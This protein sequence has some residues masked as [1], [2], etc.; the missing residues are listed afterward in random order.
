M[1]GVLDLSTTWDR[2]H[3]LAI[4]T[5][6]VLGQ[7]V[8]AAMPGQSPAAVDPVLHLKVLGGWGASVAGNPLVLPHRQ[9]EILV[10]LALHPE[11][12]SL[13][14]LHDRLY[15]EEPVST[16]TLKAEVSHL[17]TALHGHIGSRP[18]QLTMPVDSDVH[19]VLE[20]LDRGDLEEAITRRGG[21]LLPES[22]SPDIAEWR[23]YVEV[24]L[25][26]AVLADRDIGAALSMADAH[27][28]DKELQEHLVAVLPSEDPRSAAAVARVHRAVH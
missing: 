7:L 10:L 16:A 8:T 25:R 24:A 11:G 21:P 17:R 19:R 6:Q 26:T 20:A 9:V 22:E 18:Y 13:E 15:G 4:G 14:A 28:Y 27:P 12:L 5:A 2:A 1:L 3:P 23:E